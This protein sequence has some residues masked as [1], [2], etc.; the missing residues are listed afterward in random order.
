[1]VRGYLLHKL[2]DRLE[3]E[4][5]QVISAYAKEHLKAFIDDNACLW[6]NSLGS[7]DVMN[8]QFDRIKN[9]DGIQFIMV[10]SEQTL[11]PNG[12]TAQ[13]QCFLDLKI[14]VT[15]TSIV[16]DQYD[17]SCHNFVPWSSCHPHNTKKNIPYALALRTRTLCDSIA[18][19]NRQMEATAGHLLSL[20]YPIAIIND[21]MAKAKSRN[22][23]ELRREKT[24]ES[25]N[26]VLAFV[27]TFN[28]KNPQIFP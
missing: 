12:Q 18:D 22:K 27:H 16:I 13:S 20:G 5:Q 9:E 7:I 28:P 17:K 21:A 14:H 10:R 11:L 25:N 15:S 8:H 23:T 6:D 3:S 4:G 26:D 1:M 24:P 19:E 2:C